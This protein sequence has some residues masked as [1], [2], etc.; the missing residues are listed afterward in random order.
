[1]WVDDDGIR[2]DSFGDV[3]PELFVQ[4]Q[5]K[6][7]YRGI[8]DK[9]LDLVSFNSISDAKEFVNEHSDISNF[10][11]YGN[12]NW[13][14]Q[15]IS[16]NYPNDINWS[17][18]QIRVANLD[19]ECK[20]GTGFPDPAN[21]NQEITAICVEVNNKYMVFGSKEYTNE[22]P[23]NITHYHSKNEADLLYKFVMWWDELSPDVMTGW[24]IERFDIPYLINRISQIIGAEY[25]SYLAPTA[26]KYSNLAVSS[27]E[28]QG[29][30]YYILNGIS[31][32]DYMVMYKTFTYKKQERYSL[33]HIAYV[34]LRERKLDYSEYGNLGDLYDKDYNMYIDYNIR[35]T[36]LV[37]RL[38]N[39]LNLLMLAYT[40]TYMCKI[41]HVDVFS[42]VRMWDTLIY[43][44]LLSQ[45]IVVP[46]KPTYNKKTEKYRGAVVFEPKIGMHKWIVSFDLDGL[47]PHLI[48]QYGISPEMM[49]N[50]SDFDK[51][52]VRLKREADNRGIKY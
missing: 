30:T 40:L 41:P 22:L 9:S 2:H 23:D 42:Q 17:Y 28:Y 8:D 10:P 39:K 24:N 50:P 33:D 1:M 7:K 11:I 20:V 3:K 34:E 45:D 51:R 38:D 52:L 19:I 47:Y 26:R 46:P 35:D 25:I 27:R 6:T 5:N 18:D 15:Y 31:V 12:Q 43:N 49:V 13:W 4:T 29:E 48:M 44:N 37:V 14:A 21:A 36:Q 32:L 16:Q